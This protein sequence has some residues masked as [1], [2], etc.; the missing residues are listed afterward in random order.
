MKKAV[1]ASI[2]LSALV[3]GLAPALAED[4]AAPG[5]SDG[6]DYVARSVD[7]VRYQIGTSG[8]LQVRVA[9]QKA[10]SLE[11]TVVV[12]NAL[13]EPVTFDPREIRVE[14]ER[15]GGPVELRV[16]TAEEWERKQRSSARGIAAPAGPSAGADGPSAA[17]GGVQGGTAAGMDADPCSG[18][19]QGSGSDAG[20]R[21]TREDCADRGVQPIGPVGAAGGQARGTTTA[22]VA[23][24][25]TGH[26]LEPGTHSAGI[27]HIKK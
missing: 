27:V 26:T 11:A 16:Y 23:S 24:L 8:G 15:K 7:G 12:V 3:G 4:Q 20:A 19:I 1:C 17:P 5:A 2:A 18:T 9:L 21:P 13:E 25:A 6:V 10:R 22:S 14:A